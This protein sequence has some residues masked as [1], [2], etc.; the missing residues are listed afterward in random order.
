[1][2]WIDSSGARDLVDLWVHRLFSSLSG[3]A[4]L[5]GFGLLVRMIL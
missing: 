3:H 4:H 5:G 2:P 1:M